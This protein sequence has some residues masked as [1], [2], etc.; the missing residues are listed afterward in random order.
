MPDGTT[1]NFIALGSRNAS[2]SESRRTLTMCRSS[3]GKKWFHARSLESYFPRS[4]SS[5]LAFEIP[6]S[7]TVMF[8]KQGGPGGQ[9]VWVFGGNTQRAP[10]MY[11]PTIFYSLDD[12]DNLTVAVG[13]FGPAYPTSFAFNGQFWLGMGRTN[14]TNGS[15]RFLINSTNATVWLPHPTTNLELDKRGQAD[16]LQVVNGKWFAAQGSGLFVSIDALS[17]SR[18]DV[19]LFSTSPAGVPFPGDG[20]PIAFAISPFEEFWGAGG[21][22][23][24]GSVPEVPVFVYSNT[25][26]T[27]WT[28]QAP[29]IPFTPPFVGDQEVRSIA[30]GAGTFVI[31]GVGERSRFVENTIL[32]ATN[33]ASL[34][35]L[36]K[37][38]FLFNQSGPFARG[39]QKVIYSERFSLFVLCGALGDQGGTTMAWSVNPLSFDV[40][41][42][43]NGDLLGMFNYS[44]YDVAT[45]TDPLLNLTGTSSG[46]LSSSVVVPVTSSL[47]LSGSVSISNG[48]FKSGGNLTLAANSALNVSGS[49]YFSGVTEIVQGTLVSA[50]VAAVA[51]PFT[52]VLEIQ[53]R[54]FSR[55]SVTSIPLFN[56]SF[57]AGNFSSVRLVN[58]VDQCSVLGVSSIAYG[59]SSASALI[60][61]DS[62]AC[63]SSGLAAGAIAGI[64]VGTVVG[65]IV[66]AVGVVLLT[67]HLTAQRTSRMRSN[68]KMNQFQSMKD[69]QQLNVS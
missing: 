35:G 16:T 31:L 28:R 11:G 32:A 54:S 2:T 30:Y 14:V 49:I 41:A 59:S 27:N 13:G 58:M 5:S 52:S 10:G 46:G 6:Y 51:F 33:P 64:V 34:T 15:P 24:N 63:S 60:N 43:T 36:G 61:I 50:R 66:I 19:P 44:C 21:L 22:S 62:S 25:G 9:D 48:D 55:S 53:V 57:F 69:A 39:G 26:G 8:G 4:S 45:R 12:G 17:W 7:A 23:F 56:Y 18:I 65:G 20:G 67:K 38:F 42:G 40:T 37:S 1:V 3:D 68:L 29:Y 47:N